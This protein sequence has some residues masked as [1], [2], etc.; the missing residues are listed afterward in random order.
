MQSS[1]N[2]GRRCR[3]EVKMEN[4]LLLIDIQNDYF[5]G[6]KNELYHAEEAAR[7]AK[8][9]LEYCRMKHWNIYHVRH[10][11]LQQGATFFLPDSMGSEIHPSVTPQSQ[12]KVF[13]KHA[14]NAFYQTDLSSELINKNIQN[15]VICG[16]MSHMCIDTTVQ[17]A[18]DLGL[19]AILLED[20]CTTKDLE[21]NDSVIPAVT[22]H[23]TIMASLS[24]TFA[25]VV[26]TEDF[27]KSTENI[28]MI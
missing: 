6:G 5:K 7:Q 14:P 25:K 27:L 17:A 11:S 19:S 2:S 15:L 26:K 13:I 24:G 18:R 21:W 4:A 10:I 12:E 22:V 8:Q 3:K 23:N 28:N 20:A 1:A 9:V 16:M